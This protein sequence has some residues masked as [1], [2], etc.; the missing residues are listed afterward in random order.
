M[1]Q[2]K[3]FIKLSQKRRSMRN[4]SARET[5]IQRSLST[6]PVDLSI[7]HRK[8]RLLSLSPLHNI[9]LCTLLEG[10]NCRKALTCAQ[11]SHFYCTIDSLSFNIYAPSKPFHNLQFASHSKQLVERHQQSNTDLPFPSAIMTTNC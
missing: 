3:V 11:P 5:C 2:F 6:S 1:T 4:S 9:T 7:H 10:L 8:K